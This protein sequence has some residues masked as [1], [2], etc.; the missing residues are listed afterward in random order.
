M[1][2]EQLKK[3]A[4]IAGLLL[5]LVLIGRWIYIRVTPDPYTQELNESA[6]KINKKLDELKREQQKPSNTAP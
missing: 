5:V 6:D 2:T 4:A 3:I 1:G